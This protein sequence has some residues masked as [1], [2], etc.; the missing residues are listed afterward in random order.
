MNFQAFQRAGGANLPQPIPNNVG[1]LPLRPPL[2]P[3]AELP[4]PEISEPPLPGGH[5]PLLGRAVGFAC[6]RSPG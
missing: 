6:V 3:A 2:P 1:D 4:A 5:F